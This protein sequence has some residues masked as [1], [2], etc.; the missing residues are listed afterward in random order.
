MTPRRLY[1]SVLLVQAGCIAAGLALQHLYVSSAVEQAAVEEARTGLARQFTLLDSALERFNVASLQHDGQAWE[2]IV[3]TWRTAASPG[4]DIV[5]LDREGHPII[6][7]DGQ[8]GHPTTNGASQ[9]LKLVHPSAAWGRFDQPIHGALKDADGVEQAALARGLASRDGYVLLTRLPDGERIDLGLLRST[10]LAAGG[11]ALLWT[12]GLSAV[13]TFMLLTYF[14]RAPIADRSQPDVEALRQAQAL[15]RTQE[16]VIFGLAKLSDS[17]DADTGAHLERI[18]Q[19]SSLLASALRQRPEFRDQITPG[20]VQRIG[21]SSA[22][23]DIGKVGVD[24]SILRKPGSLTREERE[25]MQRHTQIGDECLREIERRL[26][27]TNFLQMAREIVSGHHEW[28]DG[29]GY[30]LGLAG[31]KIPLAAR[32]VA[33]ADVYDALRCKRVYKEA[34]PHEECI[35]LIA[36]AAG[37]Q[38]DPRVVEVFLENEDRFRQLADQFEIIEQSS[39][40][41]HSDNPNCICTGGGEHVPFK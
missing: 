34:L 39:A 9:P 24:D 37:T 28:W 33:V 5:L 29:Q 26:G 23:H 17:R 19:F 8:I 38:F 7:G 22:L 6:S 41:V 21:I 13:T 12:I 40:S 20:F 27:S 14:Q 16:I 15:V 3:A 31:E 32:I 10:L 25:R 18:A 4:D 30:P 2:R 11:I 36:E 1:F 35:R